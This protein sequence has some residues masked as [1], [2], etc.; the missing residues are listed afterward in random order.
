MVPFCRLRAAL[1]PQTIRRDFLDPLRVR[2]SFPR[3]SS[4]M[5]HART[6][7]TLLGVSA[8]LLVPFPL[9]KGRCP[10]VAG[11][12]RSRRSIPPGGPPPKTTPDLRTGLLGV[13]QP[14]RCLGCSGRGRQTLRTVNFVLLPFRA[15]AIDLWPALPYTPSELPIGRNQG[16][17]SILALCGKAR[18]PFPEQGLK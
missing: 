12:K 17:C 10:E 7:Q 11:P 3:V 8:C 4:H 9:D 18:G 14:P 13:S 1:S 6:R 2:G 15:Y 16:L 5:A